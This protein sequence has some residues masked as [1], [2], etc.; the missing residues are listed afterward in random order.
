MICLRD[1]FL[2]SGFPLPPK[3]IFHRRQRCGSRLDREK[4]LEKGIGVRRVATDTG[5]DWDSIAEWFSCKWKLIE[6]SGWQTF[7]YFNAGKSGVL[8]L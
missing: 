2:D 5:I 3:L 7:F 6:S 8:N 1:F 4:M